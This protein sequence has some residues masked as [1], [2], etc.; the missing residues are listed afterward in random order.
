M[1]EESKP[2]PRIYTT[3]LCHSIAIKQGL[4]VAVSNNLFFLRLIPFMSSPSATIS[5]PVCTFFA[6]YMQIIC[7]IEHLFV[8]LHSVLSKNETEEEYTYARCHGIGFRVM[9]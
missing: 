6:I 4:V 2:H 7:K 8:S 9:Y 5:S 3:A 1:T